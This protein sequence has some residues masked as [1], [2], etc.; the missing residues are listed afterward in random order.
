MFFVAHDVMKI[1]GGIITRVDV[2]MIQKWEVFSWVS[3]DKS[4][5]IIL[6]SLSK[7]FV[8][9][10]MGSLRTLLVIVIAT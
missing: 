6:L 2:F 9:Q 4:Q 3:L 10:V 7:T 1:E 5:I 8:T